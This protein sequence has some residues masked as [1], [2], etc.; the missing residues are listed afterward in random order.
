MNR[1]QLIRAANAIAVGTFLP[2]SARAHIRPGHLSPYTLT[3]VVDID[4]GFGAADATRSVPR[5]GVVSVGGIGGVCLPGLG[6]GAR[7]LPWLDRSIAIDSYGI[8]LHFMEADR[9]ILVGDGKT[10]FD[11]FANCDATRSTVTEIATAVAGL[12]IVLLVAGVGGT[13]GSTLAPFVAQVLRDQGILSFGVPVLPHPSESA[14]RQERAQAGVGKLRAMVNGQIPIANRGTRISPHA[15]SGLSTSSQ[16]I[17]R[18]VED[19]CRA[20]MN[21]FRMRGPVNVDFL[22]LQRTLSNQSGD[23]GVGF[24]A[25]TRENGA[26]AAA[27]Q[28][29]NHPLLGQHRLSQASAVLVSISAPLRHFNLRDSQRAWKFIRQQLSV[30]V[31]STFGT[32][33]DDNPRDEITVSILANGIQKA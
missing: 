3:P 18:T 11:P 8:E 15:V 5:I 31:W 24:A 30:D 21:P 25:V 19:V 14:Y 23:C 9:K 2:A 16:Q 12:D 29:I 6:A 7:C 13:T 32:A 22:D 33:P 26:V 1:R 28:A 17:P 27:H 10:Q 4:P 20:I